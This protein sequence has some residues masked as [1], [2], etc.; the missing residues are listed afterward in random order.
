LARSTSTGGDDAEL[1]QAAVDAASSAANDAAVVVGDGDEDGRVSTPRL[2][3]PSAAALAAA[4]PGIEE[5]ILGEKVAA[6]AAVAKPQSSPAPKPDDATTPEKTP[7]AARDADVSAPGTW[8][9]PDKTCDDPQEPKDY[10]TGDLAVA[11]AGLIGDLN[12][13]DGSNNQ[14]TKKAAYYKE[15]YTASTVDVRMKVLFLYKELLTRKN[16]HA[17]V[18]WAAKAEAHKAWISHHLN[19]LVQ[20]QK[21]LMKAAPIAQREEAAAQIENSE[22]AE[23]PIRRSP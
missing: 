20:G 21:A 5:Q 22:A 14:G 12:K 19:M 7:A 11:F 16:L 4:P 6:A 15:E 3:G 17:C 1:Q 23:A 8:L 9:G 13:Q 10:E 2:A 18:G